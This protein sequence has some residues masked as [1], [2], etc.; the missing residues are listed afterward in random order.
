MPHA[1]RRFGLLGD[2]HA[3][4]ELL[5]VALRYLVAQELDAVLAVGDIVDGPGASAR[6]ATSSSST[7]W[8]QCAGTTSAGS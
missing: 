4:D 1:L 3:E 6:A 2:I 5:A 7:A 8:S